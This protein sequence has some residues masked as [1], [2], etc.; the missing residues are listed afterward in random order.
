MRSCNTMHELPVRVKVHATDPV[1]HCPSIPTD[2]ECSVFSKA[3]NSSR[4]DYSV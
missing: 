2:V 1:I 4:A 3:G